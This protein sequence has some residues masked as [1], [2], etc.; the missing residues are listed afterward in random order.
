MGLADKTHRASSIFRAAA[1]S[2]SLGFFNF[3]VVLPPTIAFMAIF[4]VL[5]LTSWILVLSPLIGVYCLT[6]GYGWSA[7]FATLFTSGIGLF[8]FMASS[9]VLRKTFTQWMVR[10]LKFNIQIAKGGASIEP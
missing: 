5:Y 7:I 2:I 4:L 6:Q 9:W 8:L 3:L 1:A 10:Y